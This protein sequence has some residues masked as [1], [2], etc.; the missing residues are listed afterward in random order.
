MTF[1]SCYCIESV[2]LIN[3]YRDIIGLGVGGNNEAC[4]EEVVEIVC[5]CGECLSVRSE[6][7]L[8]D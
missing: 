5:A 1:V 7:V 3:V 4:M 8:L 6:F 2:F